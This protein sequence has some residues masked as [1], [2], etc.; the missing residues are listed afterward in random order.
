MPGC[1]VDGVFAMWYGKGPGVDRS[2]DAIKHA[3]MS[4]THPNGG[5][6]LAF[7]DDH[8]GK[9]SSLAHQ[10]DLALAAHEVAALW[11]PISQE[12]AAD[13]NGG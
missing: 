1:R 6:L 3:N 8:A 5:V 9:S 11:V 2:G 13:S 10:S 7:G 12:R 4:G